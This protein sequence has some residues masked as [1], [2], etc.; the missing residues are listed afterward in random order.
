MSVC[1]SGT[2][3][4]IDIYPTYMPT[5]IL[6]FVKIPPAIWALNIK[7][8]TWHCDHMKVLLDIFDIELALFF[9]EPTKWSLRES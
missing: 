1:P 5:N 4:Y 6:F 8:H 7:N 9:H 2:N 3:L